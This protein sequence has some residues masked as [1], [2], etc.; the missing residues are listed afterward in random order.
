MKER[1]KPPSLAYDSGGGRAP[2]PV[3]VSY[4]DPRTGE[5][6]ETKPEP[7]RAP[8]PCAE[9][10]AERDARHRAAVA[11]AMGISERMKARRKGGGSKGG[12]RGYRRAVLVDGVRYESVMLAAEAAGCSYKY[13]STVLSGGGAFLKGH[14]VAYAEGGPR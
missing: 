2:S 10:A 3:R 9:S 1:L 12:R 13:L 11:E 7:L 14:A 8:R 5:P 4:F 6:C